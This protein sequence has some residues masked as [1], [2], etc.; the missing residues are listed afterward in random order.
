M[1]KGGNCSKWNKFSTSLDGR[2]R[3]A[4]ETTRRQDSWLVDNEH[5]IGRQYED[6]AHSETKGPTPFSF[7]FIIFYFT[8]DYIL[9]MKLSSIV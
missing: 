5:E 6:Q 1:K 9:N 4:S 8:P 7:L 3:R 2:D